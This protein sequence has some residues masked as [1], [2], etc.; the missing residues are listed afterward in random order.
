MEQFNSFFENGFW[1]ALITSALLALAAILLIR[2][3]NRAFKRI[4]AR[5]PGNTTALTYTRRIIAVAVGTLAAMGI[6]MQVTPLQS[7]ARSLLASSGVIAVILGFAAQE[8]MG[9]LVGGF[10]LSIFKPFALGDRITLREKN[11]VGFVEDISLRHTVIRTFENT[12]VIVPNSVMNNAIVE[13]AQYQ[14][15]KVCQF[16][17]VG[18]SYNTDL[19]RAMDIIN[20]LVLR[21]PSFLDNRTPQE[22]ADGA[23][24]VVTRLID[25]GDSALKLRT[26]VWAKDAGTAYAML[27]D[28]RVQVKK[29]FDQQGIEIPFPYRTIVIKRNKKKGV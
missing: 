19:D 16:L 1:S 11:V 13:N 7:V 6:F 15:Q 22:I 21:H 26:P 27:C 23:P 4:I 14:E 29:A 24:A 18:V 17:D 8:A 2:V 9:N 28:L 25:F 20:Q 3:S 5:N 12:R 10:F